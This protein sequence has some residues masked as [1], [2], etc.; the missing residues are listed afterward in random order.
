M[1]GNSHVRF[2]GGLEGVIPP[3]YPTCDLKSRLFN[4]FDT[5]IGVVEPSF[6]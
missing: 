4:C 2:L 6:L 3:A 5:F 1:L